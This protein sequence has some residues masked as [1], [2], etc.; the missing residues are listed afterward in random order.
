MTYAL[1]LR[2]WRIY[3]SNMSEYKKRSVLNILTDFGG[4]MVILIM[5]IILPKLYVENF[6]SDTN[7]LISSI[8]NILIYVNL[9]EAGIGGA[10]TQSLYDAIAR[11]DQNGI[12]GIMSAANRFY[13]TTGLYFALIVC[14]L[15]VIYPYC[16]TSELSF[17]V[18]SSLVFFSAIPSAIK[19]F[20]QGKYTILL[21]ADNRAYILNTLSLISTLITN[22]ARVILIL[23]GKD[24]FVVQLSYVVISVIQMLGIYIIIKRK[25]KALNLSAKPD[26]IAI[27]KSKYVMVHTLSATIFSNIDVLVLTFFC[28][29]KTVSVYSVYHS[30]FLQVA[31][32]IKGV[33]NGTKASFG[34]MYSIDKETFKKTYNNFKIGYRFMAGSVLTA[35]AISTMPFIRIYTRNFMDAQYVDMVYPLLFFLANYLDVIRW[36]EVVTVNSAGFFR[37]TTKQAML[38]TMINLILSLLLVHEYGIYGVLTA[39]IISLVYR[40]T[41]FF[42]FVSRNLAGGMWIKDLSYMAVSAVVS[43]CMIYTFQL[44]IP[45]FY[46]WLYF[47]G[48]AILS[49]IISS[50]AYLIVVTGFYRKSV[51]TALLRIFKLLKG[52]VN[53]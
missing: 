44:I 1:L 34:Q 41:D 24:I 52:Q 10:A 18:I 9:L 5:G 50:S 7:G 39:T 22:F 17:R 20:F 31:Q 28:D 45:E 47:F 35:T 37:E 2:N 33:A 11:K 49:V 13:R 8:N 51:V 15:C 6:G 32:M 36:P 30:I 3:I 26:K 23:L 43:V 16:V 14:L 25:Y 48:Y 53:R 42:C 38:E 4:K 12:N 40:T 27:S 19:Y 21:E 46:N 29:L